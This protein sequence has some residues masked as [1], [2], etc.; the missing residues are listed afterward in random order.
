MHAYGTE[1]ERLAWMVW[2]RL[3]GAERNETSPFFGC[4]CTH[5]ISECSHELG[6]RLPTELY[7]S[8]LPVTWP[9]SPDHNYSL[10]TSYYITIYIQYQLTNLDLCLMCYCTTDEG[11]RIW[12]VLFWWGCWWTRLNNAPLSGHFILVITRAQVPHSRYWH[13]SDV[14]P[15]D[16]MELLCQY[17]LCG[18]RKIRVITS[19]LYEQLAKDLLLYCVPKKDT[20][21]PNARWVDSTAFEK[22]QATWFQSLLGSKTNLD[23]LRSSVTID[24]RT[25]SFFGIAGIGFCL[26]VFAISLS[27]M[28]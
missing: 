17:L 14:K 3:D 20:K 9:T 1:M 22:E 10:I 6:P 16:F 7:W 18:M 26:A 8:A 19:L 23:R 2:R 5:L 28:R 24:L 25:D 4:Y 15:E 11:P 27:F 13:N 21:K 12:N